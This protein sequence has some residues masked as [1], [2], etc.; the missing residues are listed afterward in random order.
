MLK[1]SFPCIRI[2]SYQI[3]NRNTNRI[4]FFRNISQSS[5]NIEDINF[6]VNAWSSAAEYYNYVFGIP[7]QEYSA[8]A[9][10]F[11]YL[12]FNSSKNQ[13]ILDIG[14]GTGSFTLV[15]ARKGFNVVAT[16]FSPKMI[17]N[18]EKNV[19]EEDLSNRVKSYVMD[20]QA[21]QF[22]D[23]TFDA[24]FD[25]FS[26]IFFPDRNSGLKEM[27][28]VIKPGAKAV[29]GVWSTPDNLEWIRWSNKALLTVKPEIRRSQERAFSHSLSD[30]K[31]LKLEMESAGL[32][33]IS[34]RRVTR[35]FVI[36]NPKRY[37][38][39]MA[40]ALPALKHI[41]MKHFTPNETKQVCL[42][43]DTLLRAHFKDK[44]IELKGEALIGIGTKP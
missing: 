25:M 40:A 14:A 16:D 18:L 3:W 34:I 19:Q 11:S 20:G 28:R 7:F 12:F 44:P 2:G 17:E 30:P 39:G 38:L 41:L 1:S 42:T 35:T 22:P 37:W 43:F 36:E 6:S 9:L 29:V 15:A 23:D 27:K 21:L 31:H 26:L 5:F 4:G 13:K 32:V 33:N 10:R 8:E 24:A